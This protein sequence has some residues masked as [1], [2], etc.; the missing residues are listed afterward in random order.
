MDDIINDNNSESWV[1]FV[2]SN[3]KQILLLIAVGLIIYFVEY[4]VY[5]NS[6]F[7]AIPII[8]GLQNVAS[9]HIRKQKKTKN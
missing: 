4:L 3:Y 6:R 8:P 9:T 7:F 1:E 2:M 5:F